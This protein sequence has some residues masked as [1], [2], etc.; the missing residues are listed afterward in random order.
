M[1]E[2]PKPLDPRASTA[3][4]GVQGAGGKGGGRAPVEEK[5]SLRSVQYAEIIDLVSEGE[6]QGLV[7]G[8]KSVYL[9]KVPVE[10]PDGSRNFE[11][12]DFAW[13]N[14]TQGQAALPGFP[15]VQNEVAVGLVCNAGSPVVRTITNSSVDTVR[16]TV[17]VPQL[18]FQNQE[19]GDLVGTEVEFAIDVQSN[20]GGY[21]EKY[22]TKISGKT[23]SRYQR[24]V[25]LLLAGP[26]PWDIRVRRVSPAPSGSNQQNAIWF[27]S[28]TEIQSLKLRYPNSAVHALRVSA[29]QFSRVP[30]RA[31]DMLGIRCQVPV[32]Y[33]AYTRNYSGVWNGT[34]KLSWTNNPAW[35]LYDLITSERYGLGSYVDASFHDKWKL[36]QIAQ[37]CDELVPDGRGGQEPR[38][39][40]NLVLSTRAEAYR[41]LQDLAAV[42]RGMIF[43]AASAVQFA[44]DA[45]SDAT[46]Q[47]TPANAVDGVFTYSS[48]SLK[49]RHSIAMVWWNNPSDFFARVPEVVVD[50]EMVARIGLR[51]LE[52][53]PIGVTS[54]GQAAR[55]GRWAL[56]SE[57]GEAET[58]AFATGLEG[59][60]VRLGEVFQIADPSETGGRIG[61]RVK[62][63]T[64]SVI[65][66]DAPVVLALG[67]TYAL[68][69]TFPDPAG[70]GAYVTESRAV[71]TAAG[72]TAAI[73]V[74]PAFP[75]EPQPASIW[76]LASDTVYPTTWRCI[77]VRPAGSTYEVVGVAYN[78]AKYLA[79]EQ[80]M[81][82]ERRPAAGLSAIALA[83]TDLTF[84]ETIYDERGTYRS[85]M[86]I[87][88][89]P[90]P[91]AG[92]NQRFRVTWAWERGPL[93][94][95]D[96]TDQTVDIDGLS[97]GLL[98]VT[99]R[100][101]NAAGT[102]SPP[103]RGTFN[104]LGRSSAAPF[105]TFAVT[106]ATD[107]TRI[108]EFAYTV[109]PVPKDWKGAEIRYLAGTHAS[110]D[111]DTMTPMQAAGTWFS[112]SPVAVGE[113][114][115]AGTYTF[116]ARSR[117][118]VGLSTA[119]LSVATLPATGPTF[120]L[121]LTP[122]PTPTGFG[123]TASL[124]NVWITHDAPT[125]AQGHGH[126][127]TVLY[128]LPWAGG[129][130]PVFADATVRLR[131]TG[132]TGIFP[133]APGETWRFWIKWVS[134]DGGLSVTPA[135][136]TYG[137][138]VTAG[139]LGGANLAPLAVQAANLALDA[140]DLGG[141]N[142]TGTITN[143]VRFGAA[144]IGYTVTQY[145][146]A[147]SGV[148]GNL[149][150]D[151]AQIANLHASKLT[152]G[153]ITTDKFTV[154]AATVV[155]AG[156]N[157]GDV[158]YPGAGDNT[159]TIVGTTAISIPTTG[160]PL[161]LVARVTLRLWATNTNVHFF[162]TN[163]SIYI[164][165]LPQSAD[166]SP[167]DVH[168]Y[169][170][171]GN[172]RGIVTIPIIVRKP[173]SPGTHVIAVATG[174]EC[175]NSAGGAEP[176]GGGSTLDQYI[177]IVGMENKV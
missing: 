36:Y 118:A 170:G 73:T 62:S 125:Y 43:W 52:L 165:G 24:A 103:L 95:R 65:D 68:S 17:G 32:N 59:G 106:A 30:T 130:Y 154:N 40:C 122:A 163:S 133:V 96:T 120:A 149:L 81:V 3:A 11:G 128:G 144:A 108:I 84:G 173:L 58:V 2:A 169:P 80:G 140:V 138:A 146:L 1:T 50:D 94:S 135:G 104:V 141:A 51:E 109:T 31:Y 79:V 83:P 111:W 88:W 87:G 77:S 116:A 48:T 10:N 139:Q 13:T 175:R 76:T 28:Y 27:D 112:A 119:V 159:A 5:D 98:E 74:S 8:L 113:P 82:L 137:L 150:V 45:P 161:F 15:G 147:S 60:G 37:Y 72:S 105:D 131:F 167:H 121:D 97:P 86:T 107:G 143:P 124:N 7:N 23:V 102:L 156:S 35:V 41:V 67:E 57:Q 85:R 99:V 22:A 63:G 129:A 42:F 117:D 100:G 164:D 168:A 38:F 21:V 44:Q 90:A 49:Q 162:H 166:S 174:I 110:P 134:K 54:R 136:G 151:N 153:S 126:K 47:F 66:L 176:F 177:T 34:F 157:V 29:Q 145:L 152:A 53:S 142:V 70:G 9:D 4:K 132:S 148:L 46:M 19:N 26:A 172:V 160:T 12:I 114:A 115:A 39:T 6:V 20:G 155:E 93:Q 55:V 71:T 25:R 158:A 75:Q 101:M 91:G 69:L 16:V 56:Y 18:T 64:T 127:E 78:P 123:L 33:D 92:G 61:G 171:G 89:L 14:G